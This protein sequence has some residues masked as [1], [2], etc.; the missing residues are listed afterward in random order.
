MQLFD[1]GFVHLHRASADCDVVVFGED[2]GVKVGGNVVAHVHFSHV[3]VIRHFVFGQANTL[4][5]RDRVVIIPGINFLSNTGIGTICPD[6]YIH[7]HCLC[8]PLSATFCVVNV[9]DSVGVGIVFGNIEFMNCG[10]D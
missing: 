2:P 8:Y 3:I 5:E 1:A 6:D 9:M 10:I 7:I 4:L